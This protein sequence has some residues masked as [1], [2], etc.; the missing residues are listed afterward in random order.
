MLEFVVTGWCV[1][2]K[3]VKKEGSKIIV[4]GKDG[5]Q[6]VS[7]FHVL[8]VGGQ[9]KELKEGDIL[10]AC[11]KEM[12][13]AVFRGQEVFVMDERNIWVVVRDNPKA[14]K[15]VDGVTVMEK[16]ESDFSLN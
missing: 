13:R 16:T 11:A 9:V 5:E 7:E 8:R 2:L 12:V 10:A 4:A 6:A 1:L 15:T 14:K 3:P